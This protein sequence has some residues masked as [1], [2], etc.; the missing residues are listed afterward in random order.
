[1]DAQVVMVAGM[2]RSGTGLVS[3]ILQQLGVFM[4]RN[5]SVNQESFFFQELNREVLDI[6][7]CNWRCIDFLPQA[8]DFT[9]G[10]EW[11]VKHLRERLD[12]RLISGHFGTAAL[13][14]FF[15]R[16]DAWGWKDPRNSLLLPVWRQIFPQAVI[17][18]V[19]R[20]GR[21]V[22]M[23]LVKRDMK[24]WR[25]TGVFD[26]QRQRER[27]RS[28]FQLWENYLQ[29]ISLGMPA[30]P[31]SCSIQFENLLKDPVNEVRRLADAIGLSCPA[32]LEGICSVI[33]NTRTGRFRGNEMY[34]VE[35]IAGSS[36]MM[37]EFGYSGTSA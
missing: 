21:D 22:A 19:Y 14:L 6:L 31:C 30:F 35:E 33:D 37:H 1:M 2:H 13:S 15:R 4:G 5:L 3:S 7:G 11:M 10:F 17:V 12:S 27:F 23:S 9:R 28:Y 25:N 36:Q 29:L 16:I 24:R 32:R 26:V 20:D 34:W 8:D 18:H